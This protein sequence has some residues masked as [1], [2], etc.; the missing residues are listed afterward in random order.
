MARPIRLPAG[1]TRKIDLH[2]RTIGLGA[3]ILMTFLLTPFESGSIV[4]AKNLIASRK[5]VRD[6]KKTRKMA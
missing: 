1:S 3:M 6:V 5:L 4:P 2:V